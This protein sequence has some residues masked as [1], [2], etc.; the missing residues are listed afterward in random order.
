MKICPCVW[1]APPWPALSFGQWGSAALTTHSWIRHWRCSPM[2]L[3]SKWCT[4][5][6]MLEVSRQMITDTILNGLQ[7]NASLPRWS[8]SLTI[9]LLP[10]V[11]TAYSKLCKR[12]YCYDRDVRLSICPPVCPSDALWYCIKTNKSSVTISLPTI[13]TKSPSTVV[14]RSGSSLNSK[15]VTPRDGGRALNE[16]WTQNNSKEWNL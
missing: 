4:S 8:V 12:W 6:C 13:A 7:L 9:F 11:Y 14:F 16:L 2:S 3:E 1:V 10:A 5:I 15:V